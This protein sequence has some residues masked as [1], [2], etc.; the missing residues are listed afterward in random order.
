[1][2]VIDVKVAQTRLKENENKFMR[3]FGDQWLFCKCK[4]E[5]V[6]ECHGMS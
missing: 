4:K 2:V 1:M 6:D 3:N 5:S